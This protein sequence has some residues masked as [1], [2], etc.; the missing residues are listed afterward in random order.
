MNKV[1]RICGRLFELGFI[2]LEFVDKIEDEAF[3]DI[4][5]SNESFDIEFFLKKRLVKIVALGEVQK[6]GNRGS[7]FQ[8]LYSFKEIG[9][10]DFYR[11]LILKKY[12]INILLNSGS[13]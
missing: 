2:K 12:S 3:S 4:S 7:E 11:L 5:F 1:E 10:D 6:A 13:N 9:I 8:E